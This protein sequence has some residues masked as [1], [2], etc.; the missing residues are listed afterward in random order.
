[1]RYKSFWLS[2]ACVV[3]GESAIA[4]SNITVDNSLGA[5]TTV[6]TPNVNINGI[7]S[8]RISGGA[9][10]GVNLFH[11]FR[12][13]NINSGRGAYFTNPAGI[14]NI[15]TRV[16][17]TNPS[18]ILGSLGVLGNANLFFMNPNGIIFGE[19]ARLDIKGSFVGTTANGIGLTNGE[20]FSSDSLDRLPSQLLNVNP[21]AF[22]FN[23]I[24]N[25]Q[26]NSIQVDKATLSVPDTKS[27]LL[28]GGNVS[29]NNGQLVVPGGRVELG[30]LATTG[31]IGLN[32]TGNNVSLSFPEAVAL[33]DVLLTNG[34]NIDVSDK[35]QGSVTLTARNLDISGRSNIL[36]GIKP[37]L[38]AATNE[39]GNITLNGTGTVKINQESR[40]ANVVNLD[41]TGNA[42]D[43]NVNGNLVELT[44]GG[45]IRTRT[46]GSGDAG[47]INIKAG[48]IFIIN[49]AYRTPGNNPELDEKPALD[50]SNY[51]NDSR[52][53]FGTGRS[54]NIFLE[55]RGSI[56][57]T[58]LGEEPEN[59]VI[60][61]FNRRGGKG[62]G[63]IS[64]K[65]NGSIFLSN[66][67]LVS[68]ILSD[69][70]RAGDITLQ[71]NESVSLVNNSSLVAT[72]FRRGESG[73]IKVQSFGPV[74]V[75]ASM[76]SSNI[77][78]TDL[79]FRPA[80][81][82]AGNIYIDGRSVSI[83]DG[84]L[85]TSR[86]FNSENPGNIQ[87]NAQEFV[88]LSGTG[89]FPP[90]KGYRPQNYIYSSL[91]TS[92]EQAAQGPGGNI[93]ITTHTLRVF[94]GANI[95]ADSKSTFSGGN[96][97]VNAKVVELSGG[98]Q[99]FTTTSNSGKA[100]EITLQVA[101]RISISGRNPS[102]DDTL[103]K[104]IAFELDKGRSQGRSDAES[105]NAAK[106]AIGSI[107][108]ASGLFA[109]TSEA[110]TGQGGSLNI[111]TGEFIV[112]DGAQVSVNSEGFGSAGTLRVKSH[113]IF[114]DNQG[115]LQAATASQ[116]GGNI[117]LE[118]RDFILMRRNSLIS[119]GASNNAQGGNITIKQPFIIAVPRE[120][121]DIIANADQGRGGTITI[122]SPGVYGL[123]KRS[124][125]TDFSD[126]NAS[127]QAGNQLDG[128]VEI[129]DPS[130]DPSQELVN[131]PVEIVEPTL[132]QSCQAGAGRNENRFVITGRGGLPASPTEPLLSDAVLADW[133]AVDLE[134]KTD[135]T[136]SVIKNHNYSNHKPILEATRLVVN[137]KGE[138]FLT[139][140]ASTFTLH[141]SC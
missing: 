59:K 80:E 60:S 7:Q 86:S 31:K 78:S 122:T 125:L 20:I 57:L 1:M 66:A 91:T 68:S 79:R 54:G 140:D 120:N 129:N 10:R 117:D 83:T 73:N 11:S 139:A 18:K 119:A 40:V 137:G 109:N 65:A 21:N 96:I 3:I 29:L 97:T 45:Q 90:R 133:I 43:I 116:E 101:E 89:T 111:T 138:V 136:Q 8:D 75:G 15:L 100:G 70:A 103:N 104:V 5:E 58:G 52:R 123:L 41:T 118:V 126:I 30:G 34:T 88:E 127:S 16:T 130:I 55:A 49:P 128:I 25:Q 93:T 132:A 56:S 62:G 6:V 37:G 53:G 131:L 27:L 2:L 13:F 135:S 42:G 110:S 113:S 106:S 115:K 38:T 22:L 77:G 92:G 63:D 114:L 47:D 32:L 87:I 48:D 64:L 112:K 17:G 9:S 121:S 50:A 61:T 23:Q 35:A 81:G 28:L 141:R 24:A 4:Q 108:S 76:I 95:R 82:D 36:A 67:F 39:P 72:S 94:D 71:G 85:V 98:G 12:E 51:S 44:G 105:I 84:A 99:I 124:Q 46:L 69:A 19:N 14:E 26:I 107:D 134:R 74:S 102:F 33:A